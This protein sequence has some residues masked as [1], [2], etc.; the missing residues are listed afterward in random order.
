LRFAGRGKGLFFYKFPIILRFDPKKKGIV[1]EPTGRPGP[2]GFVFVPGW[3]WDSHEPLKHEMYVTDNSEFGRLAA[4]M[5]GYSSFPTEINGKTRDG[6]GID[7]QIITWQKEGGWDTIPILPPT[8][9]S[10]SQIRIGI[11]A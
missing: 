9:P 6:K 7:H 4:S 1:M 2:R 10:S 8:P 11:F 5:P 3:G